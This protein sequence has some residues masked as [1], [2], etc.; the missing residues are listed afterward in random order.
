MAKTETPIEFGEG[1]VSFPCCGRNIVSFA[2]F[3]AAD[4]FVNLDV[5]R[6]NSI[7]RNYRTKRI[8]FSLGSDIVRI[9]HRSQRYKLFRDNLQCVSCGRVGNMVSLDRVLTNGK[10]TFHFNLL[11]VE[12]GEIVMMTK[13]HIKPKSKRWEEPYRQLS[14]DVCSVQYA[15]R[16]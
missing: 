6:R 3:P 8:F 4:F 11:C 12:N 15:E 9:K 5:L 1:E 10:P 2:R 7:S 13:D 16:K 14:N